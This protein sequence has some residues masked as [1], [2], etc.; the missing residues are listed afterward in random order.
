M[1]KKKILRGWVWR[2]ATP[3]HKSVQPTAK[4][5]HEMVAAP[6]VAPDL[7]LPAASEMFL[8]SGHRSLPVTEKG[9]LVGILSRSDVVRALARC[10]EIDGITV[11]PVMTPQPQ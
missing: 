11:A 7:D 2:A 4:A 1:G 3:R 10:E 8:S 5:S 6:D 9:K